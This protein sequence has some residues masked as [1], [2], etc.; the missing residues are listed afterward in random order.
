[1]FPEL[2]GPEPQG[3][4]DSKPKTGLLTGIHFVTQSKRAVSLFTSG[5]KPKRTLFAMCEEAFRA[6]I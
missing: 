6:N 1:M 4:H 5:E 2:A 3:N